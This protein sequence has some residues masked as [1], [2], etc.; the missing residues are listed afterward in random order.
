MLD[1]FKK[2]KKEA[3]CFANKTKQNKTLKMEDRQFNAMGKTTTPDEENL[4]RVCTG[5]YMFSLAK[6]L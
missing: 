5:E 4:G 3:M 2:K 6:V 1:L